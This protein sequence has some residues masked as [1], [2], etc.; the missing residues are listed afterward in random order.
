MDRQGRGR[1]YFNPRSPCGERPGSPITSFS[2]FPFQST[3]PVWGATTERYIGSTC[4]ENFNPRSPCGERR[5]G[6]YGHPDYD[7]I[8]IHAPRV[9]SDVNMWTPA[10][11]ERNFNPRS[12]CGERLCFV[13]RS[14][15][16]DNFNPRSPC[17]ERPSTAYRLNTS[18]DISIHAPRVGS[19]GM[20]PDL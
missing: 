6:S 12:P 19:D 4:R 18:N 10:A 7:L 15:K 5:I 17:G 1:F 20:L 16:G 11:A 2:V 8:S 9:G 13:V 3:L 14:K